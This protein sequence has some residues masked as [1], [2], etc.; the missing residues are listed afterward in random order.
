MISFFTS[1]CYNVL[2]MSEQGGQE[3]Y[4][5]DVEAGA[6][7][8]R[9]GLL[10]GEALLAINGE[11]VR[12]VVDYEYLY[13]NRRLCLRIRA[14]DGAEREVWVRKEEYEP[15]GLG[16]ATGLMSDMR[17]CK[18]HCVFCFI[19]QMP[20]GVRTSLHVKDDDWRM[21]FIMGNYVSLTNVDEDE[22]C[23]MLA[24]RVSPL[25]IS[26][27]ASDPALRVRMM[28]NPTAGRIME[29][30]TRL[31]DAGLRFHLQ[32]VLCPGLNDGAALERTLDDVETLLPA[33]QSLAIV[34]VGLTRFREGLTPLRPNTPEEAARLIEMLRPMQQAWRETQGTRFAFL[35]DEWYIL[36]G[37]ALPPYEEYEDFPQIENG[38]GLLR[39]FEHDLREALAEK[40]PL[41]RARRL[42]MAGG[43]SASAF[44]AWLPDMLRPYGIELSLLPVRND[45]FGGGVNVG[46]LVTGGDLVA[47]AASR[48]NGESL[49]I[50]RVMLR[51][52]EDVFLDGMTLA[53]AESALDARIF[54]VTDGINM[55][56][57][58]FRRTL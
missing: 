22:F 11:P 40:R 42:C 37:K 10:R 27:H 2:S 46:G 14:L 9:A 28:K 43:E 6:P 34:P 19:D 26:L 5:A 8:A 4:I 3:Q 48:L 15:L 51:E 16:F 39:L 35:S 50:P 57:T 31:R 52:N 17:T 25:Y 33:A 13:A 21:S 44:F 53:Q 1:S 12:D 29:R 58:M 18:N 47:Q 36:A 54:P 41:K 56:E 20:A 55:I 23:R 32:I 30:L 38:V 49:L 45:Y 7:G 24:R